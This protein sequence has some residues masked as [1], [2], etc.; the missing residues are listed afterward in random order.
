MTIQKFLQGQENFCHGFFN[1]YQS[2]ETTG[3][4]KKMLGKFRVKNGARF[5]NVGSNSI[6]LPLFDAQEVVG[7]FKPQEFPGGF[8]DS[9]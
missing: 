8:G 2:G 4:C 9:S 5:L 7:G 3:R 1:L 6:H